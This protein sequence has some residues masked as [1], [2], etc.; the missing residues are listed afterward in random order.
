MSDDGAH[1][2]WQDLFVPASDGLRLH[3]RQYGSRTAPGTPV[4][5]LPGLSRTV[6]DFDALA[7]TLATKSGLFRRVVAID[8]RG[9]GLSDYDSNPK[10]YNL[11][12]ELAD[13]VT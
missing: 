6:A 4:I 9:R 10:N 3:V 2:D 5:C 11:A 13:V 12:V 1:D 8:S 7:P